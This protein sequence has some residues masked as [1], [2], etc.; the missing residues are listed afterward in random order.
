MCNWF[1]RVVKKK[2]KMD[3]KALIVPAVV[4]EKENFHRSISISSGTGAD[5]ILNWKWF[6]FFIFSLNS[7]FH[8]MHAR[9]SSICLFLWRVTCVCVCVECIAR[10]CNYVVLF[11]CIFLFKLTRQLKTILNLPFRLINNNQIKMFR[12]R[13][14]FVYLCFSYRTLVLFISIFN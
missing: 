6:F 11:V 13:Y 3:P 9:F 2:M 14:L 12:F 1:D 5:S 10:V 7:L 4:L 8:W